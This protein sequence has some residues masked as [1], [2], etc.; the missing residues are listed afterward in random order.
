MNIYMIEM[1]AVFMVTASTLAI[2]IRFVPRQL[3][4]LGY[5]L[6]LLLLSGITT[7]AGTSSFS[8]S[9]YSS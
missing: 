9:G 5:L 8:R 3:A 2:D 6:A 4:L 7:F 1:A